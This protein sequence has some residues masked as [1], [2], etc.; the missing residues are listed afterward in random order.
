L[1][2]IEKTIRRRI[3]RM[4]HHRNSRETGTPNTPTE[5]WGKSFGLYTRICVPHIAFTTDVSTSASPIVTMIMEIIG[6][7]I[8]GRRTTR[9][10]ARARRAE[11]AIVM[12]SA[13]MK[14][15]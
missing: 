9:S 5:V 12:N 10:M 8:M 11:K 15:T 1:K 14:G 13:G 4:K 3:E 6:S 7:P 2:K